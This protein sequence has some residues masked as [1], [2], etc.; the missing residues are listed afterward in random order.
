ME[1]GVPQGSILGPFLFFSSLWN[2]GVPQRSILEP[3]LLIFINDLLGLVS[4]ESTT[5]ILFTY[6]SNKLNTSR[7]I[8]VMLD[9]ASQQ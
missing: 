1:S 3:F 6:Y 9:M 2:E 7:M 5:I 4:S 8:V